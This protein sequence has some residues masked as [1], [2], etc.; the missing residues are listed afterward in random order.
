MLQPSQVQ[1]VAVRYA[2]E[3]AELRNFLGR[4]GLS[5]DTNETLAEV[6]RRLDEDRSFHR[7][8]TSHIWVL[9]HSHGNTVGYADLLGVLAVAAAGTRF[10][11]RSGENEAHALLRFILEARD[12]A[13]QPVRSA[14][15]SSPAEEASASP[16]S[17]IDAPDA[18]PVSMPAQTEIPRSHQQFERE[19]TGWGASPPEP[20][21][22]T[23]SNG[24]TR[25]LVVPSEPI[26]HWPVEESPDTEDIPLHLSTDGLQDASE[27]PPNLPVEAE[28]HTVIEFPRT[29]SL[30]EEAS[31]A[32]VD[33]PLQPEPRPE[34]Q[35]QEVV[36][37]RELPPV[38]DRITGATAE[39]HGNRRSRLA[40]IAGIAACLVAG[41]AWWLHVSHAGQMAPAP[42]TDGPSPTSQAA[43]SQLA[44]PQLASY[45]TMANPT[46][47]V[48]SKAA[49]PS[50]APVPSP[51][52]QTRVVP[53]AKFTRRVEQHSGKPA[54]ARI[55]A[56]VHPPVATHAPE[57]RMLSADNS[58]VPVTEPVAAPPAP[59]T[60]HSVASRSVA[61]APSANKPA[62][63]S[64]IQAPIIRSSPLTAKAPAPPTPANTLTQRLDSATISKEQQAE[65][66]AT[67]R[68][69]P[70]LLRRTPD[71][72]SSS[73]D[74]LV[75]SSSTPNI[76]GMNNTN[77]PIASGVVHPS[78]MGIMS[79]NL[80][81]S[82]AASYPQNASA[83]RVQGQVKVEAVVDASGNVSA[84]RVIS[85]P[86]MLRDAALNAVQ[87]WRYRPYKPD[88]KPR[89]F[90]T[91]AVMDFQ[92][93]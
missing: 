43:P 45:G 82:P 63:S 78:S 25:P 74:A 57:Q 19:Q 59:A 62:G 60:S 38:Q 8:L 32:P 91:I 6:V 81:Y 15:A 42:I 24:D 26:P 39:Q 47:L 3:I 76:G 9:E 92:L 29:V 79:S 1:D 52:A 58:H 68:R 90:T 18:S 44:S 4:T 65:F 21:S 55:P 17:A 86:A 10:A 49:Q 23:E 77:T 35:A 37:H 50:V 22:A 89:T 41:G 84:A 67:G 53:P 70:R 64:N 34:E 46:V 2:A 69:Y 80:M 48:Q 33:L 7:D 16:L 56:V 31:P 14:V 66:D 87:H 93:Q 83:A 13:M 85:G 75:A 71:G 51:S 72:G 88:G 54:T 73:L 28:A 27:L 40:W 61:S 36:L 5:L 11:A 12:S 20:P 30:R